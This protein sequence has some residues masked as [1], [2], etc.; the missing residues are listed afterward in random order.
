M[1][2][3]VQTMDGLNY[4][5]RSRWNLPHRSVYT[6]VYGKAFW[7]EA[8]RIHRSDGRPQGHKY[9]KTLK[10]PDKVSY[11]LGSLTWKLNLG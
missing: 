9:R 1:Q 6:G 4:P 2:L 5:N 7:S 8:G 10:I 3:L 11:N